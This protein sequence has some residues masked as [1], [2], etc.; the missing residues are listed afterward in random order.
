MFNIRQSISPTHTPARL[1]CVI[2]R[3]MLIT[4]L[5]ALLLNCF[6]VLAAE[7]EKTDTVVLRLHFRQGEAVVRP[8]YMNNQATIDSIRSIFTSDTISKQSKV[9]ITTSTSIEGNRDI[10][11]RLRRL[12]AM[13]MADIIREHSSSADIIIGNSTVSEPTYPD[14]PAMW[15]YDRFAEG[16]VTTSYIVPDSLCP[17]N[18]LLSLTEPALDISVSDSIIA[19]RHDTPSLASTPNKPSAAPR[20]RYMSLQTNM[21]YDIAAL[22]SI[23]FEY[24]FGQ[25]IT[26]A[27]HWT[28]GWW[29]NDRE[30]RYWRAYGGDITARYWFGKAA[31]I[32]PLTGHHAGAYFQTLIYDFEFG[33]KGYLAGQPG[34]SL[35]QRGNYAVG[36]E[37]GYSLPV[38]R[39][40]NIDFS[41]GIGYMWGRYYEYIPLDGHYVW[42]STRRL[43]YFGP[44]K[45]EI[46]LVWLLGRGNVNRKGGDNEK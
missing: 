44:T 31:G 37:Y 3:R 8:S 34:A 15:L 19:V 14:N 41:I 25:N 9:A 23:A 21:L 20:K 13:A 7:C 18:T 16:V 26:A 24:Y 35:W 30:H 32:K 4:L 40:F 2:D 10:N 43:R 11:N 27:V 5:A 1:G 29:D 6:R 39:H 17:K 22:P 33:G 36:V 45:A 38:S 28:Y 46:S 12:R 42:Q